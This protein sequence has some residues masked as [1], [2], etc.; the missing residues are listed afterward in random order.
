MFLPNYQFSNVTAEWTYRLEQ[1]IEYDNW[2]SKFGTEGVINFEK[3]IPNFVKYLQEG[4]QE[5]S[6]AIKSYKYIYGKSQIDQVNLIGE[7]Y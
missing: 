2:L 6:K 3:G 1:E 4:E 7:D 5:L